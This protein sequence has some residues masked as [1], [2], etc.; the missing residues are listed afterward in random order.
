MLVFV[1]RDM[2]LSMREAHVMMVLYVGFRIWMT[3]EAFGV[4]DPYR[5]A[6]RLGSDGVNP[7]AHRSDQALLVSRAA[8]KRQKR[9][10]GSLSIYSQPGQDEAL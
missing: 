3:L 1:L 10:S 9:A 2:A 7:V 8:Q 5:C 4:T 6:S